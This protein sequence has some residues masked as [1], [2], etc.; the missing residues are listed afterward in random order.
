MSGEQ[1]SVEEFVKDAEEILENY[2]ESKG[3]KTKNIK[4]DVA[5]RYIEMEQENLRSLSA[6]ECDEAAFLIAQKS[7]TI[8]KEINKQTSIN[9]WAKAILDLK[10][11]KHA[12]QYQG[13]FLQKEKQAISDNDGFLKMEKVRRESQM[14]IDRLSGIP[15]HLDKLIKI[16][17]DLSQSK[18]KT[19]G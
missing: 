4:E 5:D 8:Q 17:M 12:Q 18:R 14:R 10:V 7:I 1:K 11:A 6:Q 3:V 15:F 19:S 9:N 16:L 13:S 2:A